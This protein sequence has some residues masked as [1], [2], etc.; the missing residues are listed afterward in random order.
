MIT[1]QIKIMPQEKERGIPSV[2]VRYCANPGKAVYFSL[3]I[4]RVRVASLK[5]GVSQKRHLSDGY[6]GENIAKV[7][8]AAENVPITLLQRLNFIL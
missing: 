5:L 2:N 1:P 3:I 7:S 8:F 4:H 6:L